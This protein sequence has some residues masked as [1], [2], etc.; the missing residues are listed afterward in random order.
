MTRRDRCYFIGRRAVRL[1][2][3]SAADAW[4][5]LGA[6]LEEMG[7]ADVPKFNQLLWAIRYA[8][9]RGRHNQARG[10]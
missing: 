8:T 3:E 5:A 4:K 6:M 7:N 2:R 1:D 9:I 10:K